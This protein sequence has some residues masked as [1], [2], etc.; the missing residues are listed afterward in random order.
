M[1]AAIALTGEVEAALSFV[2]AGNL[3]GVALRANNDETQTR[4]EFRP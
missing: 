3:A 1:D 4:P 2:A